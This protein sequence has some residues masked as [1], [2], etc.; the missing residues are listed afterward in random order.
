[1]FSY[2][3]LSGLFPPITMSSILE[4]YDVGQS[5]QG[6]LYWNRWYPSDNIANSTE[7]V[8]KD[9]IDI[10]K[11]I[12]SRMGNLGAQFPGAQGSNDLIK[13]NDAFIYRRTVGGIVFDHVVD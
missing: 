4:I 10:S 2:I 1:M 12:I 3:R 5:L 7:P 9:T 13:V 11:N 6:L 8:G